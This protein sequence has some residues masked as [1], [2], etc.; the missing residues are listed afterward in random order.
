M[1]TSNTLAIYYQPGAYGTFVEWC[2]N[3][4]TDLSFGEDLPFTP[5]GSS[6]KFAGNPCWSLSAYEEM[7]NNLIEYKFIRGHPG[8]FNNQ[9][10]Y[11]FDLNTFYKNTKKII[12]LILKF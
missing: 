4:F 6:H 2:V 1:I 11:E 8:I 5:K 3:Y 9:Y 12:V 7:F 10:S